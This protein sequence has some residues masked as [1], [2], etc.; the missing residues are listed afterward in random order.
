[1]ILLIY[2]LKQVLIINQGRPASD[3]HLFVTTP[4]SIFLCHTFNI[5]ETMDC[6]YPFTPDVFPNCKSK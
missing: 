1:M 6:K 4:L 2:Y 5:H 3:V